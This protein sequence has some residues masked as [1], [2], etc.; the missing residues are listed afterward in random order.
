MGHAGCTMG[1]N[2]SLTWDV[3]VPEKRKVDSSILSL[4]TGLTSRNVP[5]DSL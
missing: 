1:V 4:T 2:S 5:A 3:L